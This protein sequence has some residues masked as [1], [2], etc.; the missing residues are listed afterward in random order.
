M[1]R[2]LLA[3]ML[4]AVVP[5]GSVAGGERL[6][7]NMN[8]LTK[9]ERAQHA[10]MSQALMAAVQ[11]RTELRNGYAFRLP[12]GSL[13]TAAQWVTFER[14]CCPFFTFEMEQARDE[15]PLWLRITGSEGIKAFIR[16]EFQL[17][18]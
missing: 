18:S 5:I 2:S 12:P 13:V 3:S 9:T 16:A 11:E 7:C 6:A 14:K 8:A 10:K 15:G 17:D 4:L 1:L